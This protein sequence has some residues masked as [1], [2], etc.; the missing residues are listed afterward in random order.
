M[1]HAIVL[2]TYR[3]EKT[4]QVYRA[5]SAED[6]SKRLAEFRANERV[7]EIAV[8]TLA[9]RQRARRVWEPVSEK[10]N[11]VAIGRSRA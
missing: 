5:E 8:Y 4:P 3:T 7:E 10:Q 9:E 11:V 6:L 1:T 2:V